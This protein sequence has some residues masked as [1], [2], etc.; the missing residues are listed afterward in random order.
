MSASDGQTIYIPRDLFIWNE[1]VGRLLEDH[2]KYS[3][4]D[5]KNSRFV[6]TLQIHESV[7]VDGMISEMKKWSTA[8]SV[9]N[10]ESPTKEFTTSLAHMSEVYS[11]LYDKMVQNEE[12]RKKVCDAFLKNALVF[13]PFRSAS[14]SCIKPQLKH[15]LSGSFHVLKDVCW[16]DPT[17]VA[18]K[19]LRDHGKVTTK[20]LLE[21]FYH[22][23]SKASGQQS[24]ATFFVDQLKV[25]ETPNVDEYLEMAST[26][27]ELAG[28]PSPLPLNDMLKV[29]AIL[30][31]KCIARG[32]RDSVPIESEVDVNMASFIR[33]SLDTSLKCIFPSSG[34]WVSLSDKPLLLDNKSLGK[35]FQKESG[36]HFI[37]LGD[38]FQDLRK[39]STV[40]NRKFVNEK[41]EMK[42]N[43]SLFLKACDIQRLSE[44]VERNCAPTL[45]T[46]QCVP[47]QKYFHQMIPAVQRFLYFKKQPVYEELKNEKFAE[48]LQQ[49]QFASVGKLETVYSLSTHPDVH[50]RI[51]EKSGVQPVGSTFCFYVAEEH[52]ENYDVLNGEMVKLLRVKRQ[53]SSDLSNFLV[54][55]KNYSGGDFEF[56]LEE[57]QGLEPLPDEE[58]PWCVPPPQVLEE[59]VQEASKDVVL[60]LNANTS[61]P[62]RV[63]DDGLHSWP[64]KSS[65]QFEKTLKREV[66]LNSDNTL[67]MWPPPAPPDSVKK[68]LEE[69]VQ[70]PGRPIQPL[71][72]TERPNDREGTREP[73]DRTEVMPRRNSKTLIMEAAN[74]EENY[75]TSSPNDPN[76]VK[77]NDVTLERVANDSLCGEKTESVRDVL[78]LGAQSP[79]NSERIC[80]LPVPACDARQTSPPRAY[81]SFNEEASEI[82]YDDLS[83]N[84]GDLK[85][86][87]GMQLGENPNSE[88]VGRWGERCVYEFLLNQVKVLP[89]GEN[90]DIIWLNEEANTTAPYDF[91]I[92]RHITGVNQEAES[93]TVI[94]YI[95]VK[96]T[97]SDQKEFFEISVPEL[98]FAL[99]K[100][101]ALHLYRVFNAGKP[102]CLR[103]R[104]LKNLASHLEKKNVKLFMAI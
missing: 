91:E 21:G 94:T 60:S 97:S 102:G 77:V 87:N 23:L 1:A 19:L 24:L 44:C 52:Q 70:I 17:E 90:V 9:T 89:S 92:R 57:V 3:A 28:L 74:R 27:A 38:F 88:E 36:V 68:S 64:P 103:I 6:K 81:L 53:D 69:K 50:I 72:D 79:P 99:E 32:H 84:D 61:S 5:L 101:E 34:K 58:E 39:R 37:D 73:D 15:K 42:H 82:D 86:L 2:V 100:K 49:M 83:F 76:P 45:V 22:S 59:V 67:K 96:T 12:Q 80:T 51:E 13:V 95:E 93:K 98:R 30:G 11:F 71:V 43:V 104:R 4:A 40:E 48:K 47:L 63:G 75:Q 54:A 56:F 65:A 66:E 10:K 78:P 8:S 55:V 85:V 7:T 41:E 25:D 33:Q 20:H 46:Y 31:R 62:N 26:V 29:F 18:L 14:T 35:I 16:R